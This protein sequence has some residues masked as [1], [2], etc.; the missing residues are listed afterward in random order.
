M[1]AQLP[2]ETVDHIVAYLDFND[3]RSIARVCSAFR[4]PAQLR[5]FR[6]VQIMSKAHKMYFNHTDSIL[7]SPH[8]LQYPTSLLVT[9]PMQ[10]TSF[11]S[12]WSHLP[13]MSR[14]RNMDIF[15]D[16]SD[17]SRA[18][19]ALERLGSARGIALN[20]MLDLSP[21]T[22]IPDHPL[23]INSLKVYVN[24]PA[25]HVTTRLVQKCSQSLRNLCLFLNDNI[26]PP[27]PFLPHLHELSIGTTLRLIR[28]DHPDLTSWFPFLYQHPTI[29]RI[30]LCYRFTLAVQPPPD[31]LPNL[32]FLEANP[33]IIERL[34]P[35][36]AVN[37]IRA[38]YFPTAMCR[39]PDD[40]MLRPLRKPFVSVTT[41]AIM[42]NVHLPNDVLIKII[43]ALPKLC[44]FNVEWPCDKVR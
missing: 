33:A 37:H 25:R 22:L 36:R 30:S 41:L 13:T 8:L 1:L 5:L 21:D 38:R 29:T 9:S 14:L 4:V 17:C 24:A 10:Q 23:P 3:V 34:I 26:T 11:H 20:F 2:F 32:Q 28:D 27:L 43:Q 15:L 31:L 16:P 19:S 40:I 12:L 6:N 35:G 39:F 44:D 18:L 42:T 7:S